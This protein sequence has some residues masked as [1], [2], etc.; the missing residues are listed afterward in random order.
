[1]ITIVKPKQRE[2]RKQPLGL[3]R[4]FLALLRAAQRRHLKQWQGD[5]LQGLGASLLAMAKA[6]AKSDPKQR[7]ANIASRSWSCSVNGW[8]HPNWRQL[9]P[10]SAL[11]LTYKGLVHLKTP[12]DQVLYARLI[13]ELQPRTIIELG[14]F[15]GASGLWFADQASLLCTEPVEVHSFDL[16]LECVSPDAVHPRLHFHE[17]DL[18]DFR[19]FD[20]RLLKT[21]P[22]P[23]LLVDDAHVDV[24]KVFLQLNPFLCS[25]DYYV[26]E[27]VFVHP[28]AKTVA[29]A[30]QIIEQEGYL[31]DR[32]YT[33]AF[34]YNVT[35]CPNGWLRKS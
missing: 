3:G 15:Q 24:F 9:S 27:D 35:S 5:Q 31:V 23:W 8:S 33:D 6:V 32:Y 19:T 25:G 7:F 29:L 22:H 12:F 17:V 10:E 11:A 2:P 34:G 4:G 26:F 16:H 18:K 30:T 28:T 20:K 1:M 13:W 14:S 21:L